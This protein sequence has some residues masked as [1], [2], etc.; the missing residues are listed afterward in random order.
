MPYERSRQIEMRFKLVVRLTSQER[1][2]A[3]QLA[4]KLNVSTATVHRI[5]GELKRR[6]YIVRSVRDE[7]GWHYE[8][9]SSPPNNKLF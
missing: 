2:S 8:L 1:L 9:I 6:G 3:K 7:D 4:I 5:I